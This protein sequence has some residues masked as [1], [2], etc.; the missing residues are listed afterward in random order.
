[1]LLSLLLPATALS[2]SISGC[3]L[4]ESDITAALKTPRLPAWWQE[5]GRMIHYEVEWI[6]P[7]GVARKEECSPGAMVIVELPRLG[8]TPALVTP[9]Y[10]TV[11]GARR[12]LPAGALYPQ[13]LWGDRVLEATWERGFEATLFFELQKR[14]YA[15]FQVNHHRLETALTERCGEDPWAADLDRV[16]RALLEGSF[17]SSY[18]SGRETSTGMRELPAGGYLRENLLL[19]PVQTVE[20]EGRPRLV[21]EGLYPGHH[22][23]FHRESSMELLVVNDGEHEWQWELFGKEE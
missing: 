5:R 9:V 19:P 23:F 22:S 4:I 14:E 8:N 12:L 20:V 3:A 13:D 18:L 2:L 10:E 11:G 6:D 17:R 7:K 1:L 21:L 15:Y 16:I